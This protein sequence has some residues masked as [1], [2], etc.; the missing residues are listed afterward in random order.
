MT[1]PV[2]I[3]HRAEPL[4][5]TYAHG[6]W[7]RIARGYGMGRFRIKDQRRFG[8]ELV[9]LLA[10]VAVASQT[11]VTHDSMLG[12]ILAVV[13]T[14]LYWHYGQGVAVNM[15]WHFVSLAVIF[16]ISQ[17]IGMG[18]R[19]REQ[20]LAE[21]AKLAGNLRAIWGAALTWKVQNGNKQWVRVIEQFSEDLD[22]LRA[23]HQTYDELLVALTAYFDTPR[24]GRA[25]HALSWC[26][27]EQ[28]E[29][30]K[31]KHAAHEL[32]LCVDSA[33]GRVQKMV[34]DL[35]TVGLPGGEA[36]RLDQYVSLAAISF[37]RLTVIK[38]YRTPQ[39]FRAFARV[40]ILLV[41]ALCNLPVLASNPAVACWMR[42]KLA[43]AVAHPAHPVLATDESWP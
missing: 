17:G 35:K 37:E 33:L 8:A 4:G 14:L 11:F 20:A 34:Q 26:H 22:T 21:F 36:H 15:S 39:A 41:G 13:Y 16:P 12:C 31:L 3:T 42:C 1:D 29:Q 23:L 24:W 43:A 25:R 38:E 7:V 2:M 27:S 40:Y 28:H 18:F 5:V 19:R 30:V 9:N 6:G 32:R 10:S